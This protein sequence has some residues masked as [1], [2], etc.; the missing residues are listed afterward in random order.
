MYAGMVGGKLSASAWS[1]VSS[2]DGAMR[3][4]SNAKMLGVSDAASNSTQYPVPV[5]GTTAI[6]CKPVASLEELAAMFHMSKRSHAQSM[7]RQI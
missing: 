5:T 4:V 2:E 1:V 6:A 7:V 3:V